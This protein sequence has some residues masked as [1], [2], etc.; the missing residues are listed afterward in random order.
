MTKPAIYR[1]MLSHQG[2]VGGIVIKRIDL[3]VQFP[4]PWTVTNTAAYFQ[5]F[6]MGRILNLA[7][8]NQDQ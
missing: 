2:Q 6:P 7:C 8:Q 4:A 5:I 3:H 1:D